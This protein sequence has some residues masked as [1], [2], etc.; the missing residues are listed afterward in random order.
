M[1][2]T[3]DK[4][5]TLAVIGLFDAKDNRKFHVSQIEFDLAI[6]VIRKDG[7]TEVYVVDSPKLPN[8]NRIKFG[9]DVT[10]L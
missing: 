5:I 10:G 6:D 3:L 2:I 4:F 7:K 9:I 8:A 1:D